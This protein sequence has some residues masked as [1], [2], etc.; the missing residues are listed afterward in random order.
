MK[1]NPVVISY[2]PSS[3][4]GTAANH[5]HEEIQDALKVGIKTFLI[6]FQEVKFMDSHGLGMLVMILKDIQAGEGQLFLCS[7]G[8]Q[9][10]MLLELTSMT[11]VFCI[12]ANQ[13]EFQVKVLG[14]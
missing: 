7:L 14:D 12:F 2:P 3:L 11:Q 5:L 9:A 4:V 13:A 6:N 1:S 8:D 10:K